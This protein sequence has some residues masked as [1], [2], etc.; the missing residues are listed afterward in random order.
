MVP[1]EQDSVWPDR[2]FVRP[3]LGGR[4]NYYGW[5]YFSMDNVWLAVFYPLISW[6]VASCFALLALY[7]V[8][9]V[10]VSRGLRD[11]QKWMERNRPSTG[12]RSQPED[13]RPI[14]PSPSRVEPSR[15]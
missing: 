4:N 8:V 10:A 11:H 3:E 2:V 14:S 7:G 9:R 13:Y 5:K 12:G 15:H 1:A 6:V